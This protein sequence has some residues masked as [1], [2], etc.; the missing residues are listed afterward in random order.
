MQALK[1]GRE[2]CARQIMLILLQSHHGG[3][4]LRPVAGFVHR[5]DFVFQGFVCASSATLHKTVLHLKPL[6]SFPTGENVV[7]ELIFIQLT[8]P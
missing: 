3:I 8:L 7:K 6:I 4:A 2:F 5:N 1:V